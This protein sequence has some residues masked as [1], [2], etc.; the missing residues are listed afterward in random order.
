M[1]AYFKT[2]LRQCAATWRRPGDAI[3]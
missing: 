3:R 1:G 2:T